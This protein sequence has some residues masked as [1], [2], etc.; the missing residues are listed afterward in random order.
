MEGTFEI[1]LSHF[2][3]CTEGLKAEL[4]DLE[5]LFQQKNSMEEGVLSVCPEEEMNKD[6]PKERPGRGVK[7]QQTK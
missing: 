2:R 1:I 5:G 3:P 6:E 7:D 4:D